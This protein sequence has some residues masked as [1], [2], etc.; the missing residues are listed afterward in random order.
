M[1]FDQ[2]MNGSDVIE[3]IRLSMRSGIDKMPKDIADVM[4]NAIRCIEDVWCLGGPSSPFASY[5]FWHQVVQYFGC[6]RDSF[7]A[8]LGVKIVGRKCFTCM[9]IESWNCMTH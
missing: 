5:R 2:E 1:R 7:H 6:I 3:W 9:L 4:E 8:M